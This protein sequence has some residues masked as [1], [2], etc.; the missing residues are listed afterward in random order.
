MRIGFIGL[1][2]MGKP[3]A[4]NLIKAGHSLTVYNRTPVKCSPL[5]DAGARRADSPREAAEGSEIVITIVSDTPDVESVLF[6][7]G[8]VAEGAGDGAIVIDMSTIS[9]NATIGFAKRL[10]EQRC[11]MLDGPVTGGEKGAIEGTLTIMVGG[12][13]DVFE[14]CLGVFQAMGKNI[15][16]TGPSGNGQKT[17]LV[18]QIICACNIVSMTEG[19]RFAELSGLD[20]ET[21]FRVVSSGSAASWILSNL[22]GRILQNDFSPGFLIK[23][24]QKDLRLVE[25]SIRELDNEFPGT[26][27]AYRLFTEALA[28]DLGEQG[29]QGLINLYRKQ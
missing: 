19:L 3:M 22:G 26:D 24:Q 28:R 16:Y 1:G 4:L 7:P 11:E 29:T 6:G 10:S 2:I 5:V 27:L 18:N 9:P 17:K 15:V 25:E 21:T 14:K 20:L 8:G 23:L 12:K 13:R